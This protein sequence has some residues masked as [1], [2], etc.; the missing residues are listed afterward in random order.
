MAVSRLLHCKRS[1][2]SARMA[3]LAVTMAFTGAC[4]DASGPQTPSAEGFWTVWSIN[5]RALPAVVDLVEVTDGSLDLQRG[6]RFV[7]ELAGVLLDQRFRESA[8]GTWTQTGT[9]VTLNPND[10]C[11]DTLVLEPEGA[12]RLAA[13]CNGGLEFVF[14]R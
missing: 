4:G 8:V 3:L 14:V 11:S 9:S 7:L 10:G 13:D 2:R 5:G 1:A 6:G 12:L